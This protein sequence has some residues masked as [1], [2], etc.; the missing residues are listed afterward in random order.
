M[1]CQVRRFV[2]HLRPT[3]K[4]SGFWGGNDYKFR[5]GDRVLVVPFNSRAEQPADAWDEGVRRL[6]S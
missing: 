3:R 6:E 1:T 4:T 2:K 5:E